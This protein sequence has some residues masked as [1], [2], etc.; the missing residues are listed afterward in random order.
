MI[1]ML[2]KGFKTLDLKMINDLKETSNKQMSKVK[3]SIQGLQE[4]SSNK[5]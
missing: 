2:E 5:N 4:K 3:K 1:E